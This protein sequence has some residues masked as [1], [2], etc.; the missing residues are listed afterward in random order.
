MVVWSEVAISH[1][2][3]FIDEAKE[4]T[5][6]TAKNYMNKLIDYVDILETMPNLGKDVQMVIYKYNVKQ[7][8]YKKHRILYCQENDKEIGASPPHPTTTNCVL[9]SE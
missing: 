8:I 3:E 6:Q 1:I 9:N 2:T 7:I 4:G 5:E